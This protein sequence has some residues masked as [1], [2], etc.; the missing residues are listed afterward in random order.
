[1]KKK[2]HTPWWKVLLI[3]LATII[4]FLITEVV[5]DM[6]LGEEA[7][8]RI[9]TVMVAI[10]ALITIGLILGSKFIISLFKKQF[11]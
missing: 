5:V 1:M 8:R 9:M 2:H 11:G 6:I 10:P 7:V 3:S 4:I